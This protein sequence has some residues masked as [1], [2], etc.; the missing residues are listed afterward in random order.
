[1]YPQATPPVFK[2]YFITYSYTEEVVKL[3]VLKIKLKDHNKR[4]CRDGHAL[5][6]MGGRVVSE[7]NQNLLCVGMI[8]SKKNF[9]RSLDKVKETATEIFP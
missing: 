2:G 1:M 7:S 6:G 5:A 9:C 8:L 4:N 3:S